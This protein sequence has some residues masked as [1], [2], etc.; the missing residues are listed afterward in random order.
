MCLIDGE[1]LSWLLFIVAVVASFA[2]IHRP[3]QGTKIENYCVM[4]SLQITKSLPEKQK[5]DGAYEN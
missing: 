5:S 2:Q 3:C 4:L 1:S